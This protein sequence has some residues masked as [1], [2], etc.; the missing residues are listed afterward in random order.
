M[1]QDKRTKKGTVS[2]RTG[3]CNASIKSA[4]VVLGKQASEFHD[5]HKEVL[6]IR[7]GEK[8]TYCC[9]PVLF[10]ASLPPQAAA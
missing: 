8:V 9:C 1:G 2:K 5:V 7:E 6:W 4:T 3:R 10:V